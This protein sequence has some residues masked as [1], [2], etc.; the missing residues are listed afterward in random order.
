MGVEGR[1]GALC[2]EHV[3][4]TSEGG[5]RGQVFGAEY[6][7]KIRSDPG[8]CTCVQDICLWISAQSPVRHLIRS[9]SRNDI[10]SLKPLINEL[11]WARRG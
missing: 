8:R 3:R 6:S 2:P 5:L 1:R 11:E 7:R 10:G 4:F 9:S